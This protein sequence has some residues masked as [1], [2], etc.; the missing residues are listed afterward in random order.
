MI[1]YRPKQFVFLSLA[2]FIFIFLNLSCRK[3][4]TQKEKDE[5]L[6]T[7][8]IS[9]HKLDAKSTS[10]GLYYVISKEGTGDH[11]NVNSTV[12]VIYRGTL[13]NGTEFDAST[14]SGASFV[15]GNT[16]KGWQ[17]GIPYFKKGGK[18]ILI[19]PSELGYGSQATGKIPASSVLVFD[20]E[21]LDVK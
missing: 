21:L 13:T 11:P 20:V 18:G 6:I 10:S 17:E 5:K 19:I 7:Q 2:L 14:S 4:I 15:L 16:I 3:K 8:Y 9:D 1:S 12:S